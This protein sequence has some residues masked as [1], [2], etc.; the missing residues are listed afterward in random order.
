[1]SRSNRGRTIFIVSL[2]SC[3][4]TAGV[5]GSF[6]GLFIAE[7]RNTERALAIGEHLPSLPSVMLDRNGKLITEFFTDEKREIVPLDE[8]P[9][10]LLYAV[11]TK[12]DR[13]FFRHRGISPRGLLRAGWNNL[14]RTYPSGGS[15]ITQ[16]LARNLYLPDI[17]TERTVSR[18]LKEMWWALLLEKHRS[19]HEILQ[20]YL[21]VSPFGHDTFGV[22]AASMF[23]FGHSAR[24]ITLAE[25]AI[26][27]VQLS[28]VDINSPINN[29]NRSRK[30]ASRILDEMSLLGY[31][32]VS[33]TY[34]SFDAYWDSF[35]TTR[36][37][38]TTAAGERVDRAPYFSDHV[39][40]EF[41]SLFYGKPD[42]YRDGFTINTT[43]DLSYQ[44]AAEEAVS[45]G[46]RSIEMI[47]RAF[48]D[49]VAISAGDETFALLSS[50]SV[51]FDMES[52]DFT[53]ER[54][55]ASVRLL[56]E[57]ELAPVLEL[58]ALLF[59]SMD[60]SAVSRALL[61]RR[62]SASG[63][64]TISGA[65][66]MLANGTGEILTMVGGTDFGSDPVNR[67]SGLRR[68]TGT[69]LN[70]LMFALGIQD[71]GLTASTPLVDMP[72]FY[73]LPGGIY[74]FSPRTG[75]RWRGTV[76]VRDS[77]AYSL[78]APAYQAVDIVGLDRVSE[79]LGLVTGAGE[80]PR[81]F[82]LATAGIESSPLAAARA[83][84]VLGSR[85]RIVEPFAISDVRDRNGDVILDRERSMLRG[86]AS[87]VPLYGEEAAYIMTDIIASSVWNESPDRLDEGSPQT[88][89]IP[90][91][92]NASSSPNR[93]DAWAAAYSP[94]YTA[95]A[96]FGNTISGK[97]L[98][99]DLPV[100]GAAA[101]VLRGY[102]AGIYEDLPNRDFPLPPAKLVRGEVCSITG[103]LPTPECTDGVYSELF[104]PGTEPDELCRY[105]PALE[106]RRADFRDRIG[107]EL[108]LLNL[109]IPGVG[110][111]SERTA[112]P[113]GVPAEPGNP[114]LD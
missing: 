67:A 63:E 51:L 69:L 58:S 35:D 64:G 104:V 20:A 25:S 82:S 105:H 80:V 30:I 44:R 106:E 114:L 73:E 31:A 17:K 27:V 2:I 18:K 47:A 34:A 29:P 100:T 45:A 52:L 38:V 101:H 71:G 94:Y 5:I 53:G 13:T 60:L 12:E 65:L 76:T 6:I 91:V 3:F 83:F 23:F 9:S 95:S 62:E 72:A 49:R 57:S 75:D 19:K 68:K 22:D 96:W 66:V 55:S 90:I 24:E 112:I 32:D 97:T 28:N 84:S 74:A 99:D 46:V 78:A 77:V 98:G 1:M 54:E 40:R 102:M 37:N 70:P 43:L 26:L 85:G 42:L 11:L 16:V 108:M 33:E 8:L 21:D 59:D 61:R 113:D 88:R 56:V 15:T 41:E 79:T 107:R 36:S 110:S 103:M 93:E 50:L 39:A 89:N 14:V 81:D 48:L 87:R 4:C 111:G 10:H 7:I 86:I 109:D 92:L